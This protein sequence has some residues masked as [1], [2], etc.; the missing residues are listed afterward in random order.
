MLTLS[1]LSGERD[2]P[3]NKDYGMPSYTVATLVGSIRKSSLNE[4]LARAIEKL[5]PPTLRFRRVGMADLPFYNYD[6]ES[7]RPAVVQRFTA[8]IEAAEA[9]C[10]VTPEYNRSIPGMLKNAIDWGS[11]PMERNVWRDKTIAMTGA[12]PGAIG[13]AV[14]QQHLRQILAILGAVVMPGEAYI[15]FKAAELIDEEGSVHDEST[16]AFVAA[17]AQRFAALIDRMAR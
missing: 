1:A 2:T 3:A 14:A 15:S 11:K 8:E 7:R 9:V 5:A 13:T 6:L 4:R 16:R 12:S 10:I 17:F